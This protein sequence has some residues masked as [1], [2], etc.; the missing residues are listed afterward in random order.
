MKNDDELKSC[1]PLSLGYF[2]GQSNTPNKIDET[3]IYF[4][5]SIN[6][7]DI[8]NIF[9]YKYIRSLV[10]LSHFYPSSLP[11]G[12]VINLPYDRRKIK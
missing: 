10:L 5:K 1:E 9:Y 3:D 4:Y 12:G 8:K 7:S 6:S 2:V 11:R